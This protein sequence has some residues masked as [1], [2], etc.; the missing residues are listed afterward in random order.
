MLNLTLVKQTSSAE[1]SWPIHGWVNQNHNSMMD[2]SRP[3]NERSVLQISFRPGDQLN[4]STY[5]LRSDRSGNHCPPSL[6]LFR[7]DLVS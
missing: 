4:H 1:V 7:M 2:L 5:F 3:P 6:L